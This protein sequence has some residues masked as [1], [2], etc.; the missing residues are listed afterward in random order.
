MNPRKT[1]ILLA[2]AMRFSVITPQLCGLAFPLALTGL[3]Q[4]LMPGKANGSLLRSLDGTVIGS[5]LIGQNWDGPEWFHGRPS[6]TT[7]PDPN[8]ATKTIPAPYNAASSRGSNLGP[9]SKLLASRLA[10]GRRALE[11]TQPDSR[12]A[13]S[14]RHAHCLGIGSRSRHQPRQCEATGQPVAPR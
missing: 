12:N 13:H 1:L 5:R 11:D 8:D 14:C 9:T 3:A 7:D 6:A 10:E 2:P 4:R